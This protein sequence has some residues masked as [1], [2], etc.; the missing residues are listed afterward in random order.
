MR[1]AAI[2]RLRTIR[3]W[4]Q[5]P[6]MDAALEPS[7]FRKGR[8]ALGCPRRCEHCRAL[9]SEPSRQERRARLSHREVQDC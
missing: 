8:T 1:R 9:Q 5:R 4:R 6:P 2:E 7:R 3:E